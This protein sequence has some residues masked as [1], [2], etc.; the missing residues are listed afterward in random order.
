MKKNSQDKVQQ[1]GSKPFFARLLEAQDLEQVS[2]GA[3]IQT[4]KYPSDNEDCGTTEKYP[5]DGDDVFVTMKYPSD[6][7]EI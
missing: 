4:K 2:G 6:G 7:D 1:K 5:S 3:S